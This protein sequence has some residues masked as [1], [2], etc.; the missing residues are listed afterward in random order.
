MAVI[1][2]HVECLRH[3]ARALSFSPIPFKPLQ[4]PR[5]LGLRNNLIA[6]FILRKIGGV[7]VGFFLLG[8]SY[9]KSSPRTFSAATGQR[10]SGPEPLFS[11]L[12]IRFEAPLG[13]WAF[14]CIFNLIFFC[15]GIKTL[16]TCLWSA[17]IHVGSFVSILFT[18]VRCLSF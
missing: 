17:K 14:C 6:A 5:S 15:A 7:G 16:K 1:R 4:S 10:L 18:F 12:C 2:K 3:T 11:D 9:S 13:M 8:V